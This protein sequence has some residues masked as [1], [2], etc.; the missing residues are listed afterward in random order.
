M[1]YINTSNIN[2][3]ETFHNAVNSLA[4][5][6]ADVPGFDVGNYKLTEGYLRSEVNLVAGVTQYR[7]N[8]MINENQPQPNVTERRLNLQD[9]FV[10]ASIGFFV[11]VPTSQTDASYLPLTYPDPLAFTTALS[12][13]ATQ[14]LY[15]GSLNVTVNNNVLIPA[16]DL[17]RHLYVPQTQAADAIAGVSPAKQNQRNGFDGFFP[18]EPNIVFV[19]SK[20]NQVK[21]D[22]PAGIGTI[23]P[24]SRAILI[25]RG[26]LA[27]NTTVVS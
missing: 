23:T 27:Q 25:M 24:N 8:I 14:T 19:G 9:S 11:A 4:G 5:A 3:R 22:L 13:V 15:N 20:N 12:A 21:I 6:F 16:W 17:Y 26:I 2:Q 10:A 18:N 7:F 1:N